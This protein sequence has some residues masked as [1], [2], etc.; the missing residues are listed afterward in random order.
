[1]RYILIALTLLLA[2]FSGQVW[3]DVADI[4]EIPAP[5]GSAMPDTRAGW[6]DLLHSLLESTTFVL[7]AA[8][9]W[10]LIDHILLGWLDIREV[11]QG[12]SGWHRVPPN[13]RAALL[14]V[15][16]GCWIAVM[17]VFAP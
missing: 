2:S 1:M 16:G 10:T 15:Y 13:I 4:G 6:A 5:V 8:F 12:D 17:S 11:A 3:M 9:L 7:A 14:L